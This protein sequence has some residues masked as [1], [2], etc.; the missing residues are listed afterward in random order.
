[1]P[2]FPIDVLLSG[3]ATLLIAGSA[4]ASGYVA[5]G[6]PF[7]V[8]SFR[9]LASLLGLL[10]GLLIM[11]CILGRVIW[12]M[13]PIGPGLFRLDV[14]NRSASIWKVLG[15]LNLYNVSLFVHTG[16]LPVTLRWV[17]YSLVGAKIGKNVMIGGKIV[18]PEVTTS[19]YSMLA[20]STPSSI[21]AANFSS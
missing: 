3:L 4:F 18:E 1:M 6:L 13:Y 2:F 16:L 5:Y 8:D 20:G 15:Y 21:A 14:P 7:V 9:A 10:L 11:S 17:V 12:R 19:A